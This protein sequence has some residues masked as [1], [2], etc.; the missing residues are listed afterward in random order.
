VSDLNRT[1]LKTYDVKG[2]EKNLPA[3][4]PCVTFYSY[5]LLISNGEKLL[6]AHAASQVEE[7]PRWMPQTPLFVSVHLEAKAAGT[8]RLLSCVTAQFLAPNVEAA[9]LSLS[10]QQNPYAL[11]SIQSSESENSPS[12]SSRLIWEVPGSHLRVPL[13]QGHDTLTFWNI[14]YFVL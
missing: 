4:R 10:V 1:G 11:H 5:N 9:R 6:E 8:R 12:R 13:V 3:S 2:E 7:Q 14:L